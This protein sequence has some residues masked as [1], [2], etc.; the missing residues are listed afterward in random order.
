MPFRCLSV[1][2]APGHRAESALPLCCVESFYQGA[3]KS[4]PA[5]LFGRVTSI[6]SHLLCCS[7]LELWICAKTECSGLEF[8]LFLKVEGINQS[9]GLAGECT[10]SPE[11]AAVWGAAEDQSCGKWWGDYV[12]LQLNVLVTV[13]VNTN[14][15]LTSSN[16]CWREVQCKLG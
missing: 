15:R 12:V 6:C 13:T 11:V 2:A 10:V 9:Q 3:A 7:N 5:V 8:H 4:L 16:T 14:V 1:A